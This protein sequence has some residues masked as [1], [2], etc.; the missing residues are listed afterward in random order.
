MYNNAMFNSLKASSVYF[1]A[2]DCR[3]R[4][5]LGKLKKETK[6][7]IQGSFRETFKNCQATG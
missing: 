1:C 5:V 2:T 6:K 4:S 7:E 3:F